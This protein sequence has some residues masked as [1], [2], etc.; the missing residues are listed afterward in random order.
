MGC[1][2]CPTQRETFYL[3]CGTVARRPDVFHTIIK[4]HSS[5]WR[6]CHRVYG[7]LKNNNGTIRWGSHW[8][9]DKE[10]VTLSIQL[11]TPPPPCLWVF[12]Y[13]S[14]GRSLHSILLCR[15]PAWVETSLSTTFTGGELCFQSSQ[16]GFPSIAAWRAGGSVYFTKPPCYQFVV[17]GN[18]RDR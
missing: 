17:M 15:L 12:D 9:C 1:F 14:C 4:T 13:Q 5:F 6:H 8:V 10:S 16:N 11:G 3:H 18:T 7:P 2:L